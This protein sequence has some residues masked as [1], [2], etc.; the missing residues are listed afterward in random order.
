MHYFYLLAPKGPSAVPRGDWFAPEG[1]LTV[2]M[3]LKHV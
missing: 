1:S 3:L 2:V